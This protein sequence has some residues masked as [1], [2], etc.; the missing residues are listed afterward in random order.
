MPNTQSPN[1]VF[2]Y[3][4]RYHALKTG[5]PMLAKLTLKNGQLDYERIEI[6]RVGTGTKSVR[7]KGSY[8][9]LDGDV[10]LQIDGGYADVCIVHRGLQFAI[11]WG[12]S[13]NLSAQ[14]PWLIDFLAGDPLS[15]LH[16]LP[17][18]EHHLEFM[19]ER[20]ILRPGEEPALLDL[21]A[22]LHDVAAA[23]SGLRRH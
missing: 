21:I 23:P 17:K 14:I 16:A 7:L 8:S 9:G 22:K 12:D 10:F 6:P 20:G 15:V 13:E 3:D 18:L 1:Y 19:R 5:P 2:E 11:W 4:T